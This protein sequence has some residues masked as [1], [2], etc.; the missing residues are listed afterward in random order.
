MKLVLQTDIAERIEKKVIVTGD[1]N[2]KHAYWGGNKTEQRKELLDWVYSLKLN[3]LN[4]GHLP[5]L[6]RSTGSSYI[7]LTMC[8]DTT[9]M[10]TPT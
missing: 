6:V 10:L 9:M 4:D 3:I 1:F 5:T 7:D 2:A 8:C